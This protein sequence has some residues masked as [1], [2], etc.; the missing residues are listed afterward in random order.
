MFSESL[1]SVVAFPCFCF[2]KKRCCWYNC[3]QGSWITQSGGE[4]DRDHHGGSNQSFPLPDIFLLD[5][6]FCSLAPKNKIQVYCGINRFQR[7]GNHC[8]LVSCTHLL[9]T[10]CTFHTNCTTCFQKSTSHHVGEVRLC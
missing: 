9:Y 10:Q 1:T 8:T 3:C 5:A 4:S 2:L 7:D 6:S